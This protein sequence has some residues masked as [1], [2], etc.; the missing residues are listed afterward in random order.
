MGKLFMF[1]MDGVIIDTENVWAQ[2]ELD[3]FND[4]YGVELY[5]EVEEK[6]KGIRL[7]DEHELL[8]SLGFSLPYEDFIRRYNEQAQKVFG[9]AKLTEGVEDFLDFLNREGFKIALVSSSPKDWI[10]MTFAK[11]SNSHL[12]SSVLSLNDREDLQGKPA[13]D[14][15]IEMMK[16]MGANPNDSYILEDSNR[17]LE[18]ARNSGAYTICFQAHL[19]DKTQSGEAH[20]YA[21][22]FTDIADLIRNFKNQS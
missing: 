4:F 18:A 3:F 10:D 2:Q 21:Q 15:Y 7:K 16:L 5:K 8:K 9:Q 20:F 1:D 19:P 17:G 14:G 6:I 12:F 11:L 13:P 22:K